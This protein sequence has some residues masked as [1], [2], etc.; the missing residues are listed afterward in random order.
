MPFIAYVIDW[1]SVFGDLLDLSSCSESLYFL[2]S[3]LAVS[4]F[5]CESM[6]CQCFN[7]YLFK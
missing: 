5:V 7:F 1:A 4:C 2:L 3:I 6:E